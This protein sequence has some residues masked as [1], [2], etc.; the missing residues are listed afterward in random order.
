MSNIIADNKRIALNTF[1]LYLRQVLVLFLTLYLSRLVLEVLGVEDFGIYNVVGGFVA[2]FAFM[3]ASMSNGVQRFFNVD[4]GETG[5]MNITKIHSTSIYIQLLLACVFLVIAESI[6]LWYIN[7]VMVIPYSRL[8][9]AN[10]VFQLSVLSLV[11]VILQVPYVAAVMAYEKMNFF[12]LVSVLDVVLRFISV[13]IMTFIHNT[14]Y[15]I[16]YSCV[17]MLVSATSF[18]FYYFYSRKNFRH[19]VFE[20]AF[21]KILFRQMLS[22]SGW[23]IFGSFAYMIKDQG[24]NMLLNLYFGPVVNAARAISYQ[25]SSALNGFSTNIFTAFRPQLMQSYSSKDY[26]RTTFLMFTMSK[27]TF[28]L[29]VFIAFPII[30]E[31]HYILN[32]WLGG[33]VPHQTGI[34]T[35]LV[36]LN[37]LVTNFNPPISQV[38]HATGYMRKYQI[39]TSIVLT[40]ILPVSWLFLYLGYSAISVFWISLVISIFN[41]L[42][43][44]IVL[45]EIYDYSMRQYLSKVLLP[46]IVVCC[47]V[48]PFPYVVHIFM[49]TGLIRL[50]SVVLVNLLVSLF[51][52]YFLGLTEAEKN[53]IIT[54]MR[55]LLNKL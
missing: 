12:A 11:F 21:D 8:E 45:K 1:F 46:C 50:I 13:Y 41:Q 24:L 22:F 39:I 54:K 44:L 27:F 31:I 10:W 33:N 43:C 26:R 9:A 7:N 18:L 40:S 14:D 28:F 36:I 6:G 15:L 25:V 35:V 48:F 42:I 34:F 55:T 30:I 17:I 23:N 53:I 3:N 29:M 47:V 51:A 5:G 52:I 38:V 16:L 20:K 2:M 37:M 19:I 4:I 49:E 32:I